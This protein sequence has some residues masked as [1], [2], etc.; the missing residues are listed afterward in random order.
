MSELPFVLLDVETTGLSPK[1]D[2]VV[3]IAWMEIDAD[4]NIVDRD[5]SLIDPERSIP[6]HVSAVHGITDRMVV[7]APT[8]ADYF[9]ILL[10]GAFRNPICLIAQNSQFDYSFIKPHLHADTI[11]MCTLKLARRLYPDAENHKL[12]TLAYMFGLVNETTRLHSADG[13]LSILLGLVKRMCEDAQTDLH[14][15]LALANEPAVITKMP[16]GKHKGVALKALPASY[17]HWLLH[18]T[19]NLDA[20][21]RAALENL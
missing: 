2:R 3:E 8:L 9:N 17:V 12:G 19:D 5:M 20:D 15:L 1:T 18:K 6:A 11:Q 10:D 14:G 16:F 7:G 21:L 4:L 13:D